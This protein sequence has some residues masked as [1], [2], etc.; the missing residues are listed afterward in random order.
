MKTNRRRRYRARKQVLR[1]SKLDPEDIRAA[2]DSFVAKLL[3]ATSAVE[4]QKAIVSR[5]NYLRTEL[6]RMSRK[7]VEKYGN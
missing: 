5:R 7:D 6:R 1:T 3:N 2:T 4:V